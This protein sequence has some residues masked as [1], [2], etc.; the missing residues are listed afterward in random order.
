MQSVKILIYFKKKK[1]KKKIV[2]GLTFSFL[3]GTTARCLL[4]VHKTLIQR[5]SKLEIHSIEFYK[6]PF[7]LLDRNRLRVADLG[8]AGGGRPGPLAK[9]DDRKVEKYRPLPSRTGLRIGGGV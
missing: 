8:V 9:A 7:Y 2:P 5:T 1:E 3:W 4:Q 6:L